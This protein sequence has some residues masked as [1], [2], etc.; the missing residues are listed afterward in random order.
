M[1]ARNARKGHNYEL[2]VI[3]RL[4]TILSTLNLIKND[5]DLIVSSRS[6]SRRLDAKKIDLVSNILPCYVQ[7]KS[8]STTPQIHKILTDPKTPEDRPLVI[9][10]KLTK[11]KKNRFMAQGEYVYMGS[12]FFHT[13]LINYLDKN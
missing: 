10:H 7:C 1:P 3:K 13:L 8:T 12:E 2:D 6:E 4:N 5:S 11:K 9:Y